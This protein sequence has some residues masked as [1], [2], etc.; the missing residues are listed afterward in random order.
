MRCNL[1][2]FFYTS[3]AAVILAGCGGN[4]STE[5]V[6]ST[7]IDAYP[8]LASHTGLDQTD[9]DRITQ[10]PIVAGSSNNMEISM[11][12]IKS[13]VLGAGIYKQNGTFNSFPIFDLGSINEAGLLVKNS[14]GIFTE[15]QTISMSSTTEGRSDSFDF[16]ARAAASLDVAGFKASAAAEGQET[17]TKVKNSG[18]A[19]V[20]FQRTVSAGN[21]PTLKIITAIGESGL[22]F[23]RHLKGKPLSQ[24]TLSLIVMPN[25]CNSQKDAPPGG[26]ICSVTLKDDGRY[27]EAYSDIYQRVQ[28]LGEMINQFSTMREQR[29]SLKSDDGRRDEMLK[30]MQLLRANIRARIE[31]FYLVYGQAFVSSLY[32]MADATGVGTIDWNNETGSKSTR[33]AASIAGGYSNFVAAGRT[34]VDISRLA[35]SGWAKSF[36]SVKVDV[37]SNPAGFVNT[38]TWADDI[39]SALKASKTNQPSVPMADLSKNPS[40]TLP[41]AAEK[42][43]PLLPPKGTY[44][45]L[46]EWKEARAYLKNG[47]QDDIER[48]KQGRAVNDLF[49]NLPGRRQSLQG[50]SASN[51]EPINISAFHDEITRLDRVRGTL[52]NRPLLA[53]DSGNIVTIK[54]HYVSGFD[55]TD[56]EDVLPQLRPNLKIDGDE[57][58]EPEYYPNATRLRMLVSRVA[59][60]SAYIAFLQNIE[61][62]SGVN[63]TMAQ[64]FSDFNKRF[65]ETSFNI[66]RQMNNAGNDIT[67]VVLDAHIQSMVGQSDQDKSELY[68]IANDIDLYRYFRW[69]ILS[70]KSAEIWADGAG[71]F[72]PF[73]F[74]NSSNKPGLTFFDVQAIGR[75]RDGVPFIRSNMDTVY[76]KATDNP[77]DFYKNRNIP[78]QTPWYPVFRYNG[79]SSSLLYMQFAGAN[80]I[81][82]GRKYIVMPVSKNPTTLNGRS[83]QKIEANPINPDAVLTERMI[84]LLMD[85]QNSFMELPAFNFDALGGY[86]KFALHFPESTPDPRHYERFRVVLMPL[87]LGQSTAAAPSA[88][89]DGYQAVDWKA[90]YKAFDVTDLGYKQPDV[91]SPHLRDSNLKLVNTCSIGWDCTGGG[92][93]GRA[94]VLLPINKRT[95]EN[96][97]KTAF[98]WGNQR[99]LTELTNRSDYGYYDSLRFLH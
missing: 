15:K 40:V 13:M 58:K 49:L 85:P 74:K 82:Y 9:I 47:E 96:E 69:T 83:E 27:G 23:S 50:G 12:S 1:I 7:S 73:S 79:K 6:P 95:A 43:E 45:N 64:K 52:N 22:D 4:D 16:K 34:E 19:S 70:P 44:S 76:A 66:L 51:L 26:L 68:S 75:E 54:D 97:Y 60:A 46:E 48:D 77:L 38:K 80:M 3:V 36:E 78:F 57:A 37:T 35:A 53:N 25:K 88:V 67:S 14:D 20:V 28:I 29:N 62:V 33:W 87:T 2:P 59:D 94:I 39:T 61:P 18:D 84:N 17:T 99:S 81:V 71:G 21:T 30:S 89:I 65:S 5:S 11:Q 31:D 55:L 93:G 90:G 63:A 41:K 72:I 10:A 86:R 24:E 91:S 8:L 98:R 56:F 92:L 42:K 32:T